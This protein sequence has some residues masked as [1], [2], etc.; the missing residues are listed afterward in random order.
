MTNAYTSIVTTPGYGDE[1]VKAA[2]DLAISWVLREQ[3]MYRA[4]VDK[5]PERPSMPG[6]SVILTKNDYFADAAVTAAKTPLSE[7]V[8]PDSVK[9]PTAIPVTLSFNEYGFP[10]LRTNKLKVMSFSD[11]DATIARAVGQHMAETLDELVQDVMVTGTHITRSAG[12]AAENLVTAADVLKATDIRKS[13]TA[14]RSR[15]A[16]PMDGQFYAGG[17]HPKAIHDL[18]EETGSGSWRVPSEYG[19]D[20][21]QIW[22]GEFGEFEGVRFVQNT[23]TRNTATGASSAQVFRTFLMGREAIAEGILQE[24]GF[25]IGTITDKLGRFLPVGWYGVGGWCLYRDEAL[26]TIQSGSSVASL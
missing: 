8:D 20:Q 13:V 7:E 4:W 16:V 21:G 12:R 23:R 22:R 19:V 14:L 1:T 26:Q 3:P 5:R 15:K 2:Y 25:T 18:R 10:V 11:V 17:A 6:S 9:M 24:F